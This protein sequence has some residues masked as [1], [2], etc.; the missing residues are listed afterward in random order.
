M[1]RTFD[2]FQEIAHGIVAEAGAQP[3][4]SRFHDEPSAL[5]PSSGRERMSQKVIHNL[6]QR[7]T[8]PARFRFEALRDVVLQ[9]Q[10]GPGA[11][12]MM[13]EMEHLDVK[14][15]RREAPRASTLVGCLRGDGDTV[16]CFE[17][18]A[19]ARVSGR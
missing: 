5:G 18:A 12:I 19:A 16:A 7:L 8:R 2:G 4:G 13:L 3:K 6:F 17:D 14:V 11:H 10:R 1:F 15:A 9:G